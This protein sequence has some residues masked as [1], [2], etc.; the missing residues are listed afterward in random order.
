L[1]GSAR[2]QWVAIGGHLGLVLTSLEGLDDVG[3]HKAGSL[4]RGLLNGRI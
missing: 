4:C 1:V 2:Y 3:L